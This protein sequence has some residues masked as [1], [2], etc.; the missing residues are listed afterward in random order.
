MEALARETGISAPSLYK[1]F[2]SRESLLSSVYNCFMKEIESLVN[3]SDKY[4]NPEK[5]FQI[6][7]LK[8]S[9]YYEKYPFAVNLLIFNEK[10]SEFKNEEFFLILKKIKQ[11]VI[12]RI[13]K[14]AEYN[15]ISSEKI[16]SEMYFFILSA[17]FYG[18]FSMP[19]NNHR[20]KSEEISETFLKILSESFDS[21]LENTGKNSDSEELHKI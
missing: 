2:S 13:L 1:F 18:A 6:L 4:K 9:E 17:L 8:L 12:K 3:F 20:T 5:E 11:T 10:N 15:G 21:D 7:I 14:C 19:G 16:N